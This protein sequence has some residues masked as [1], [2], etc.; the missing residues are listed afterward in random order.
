MVAQVR[1]KGRNWTQYGHVNEENGTDL[2]MA[3]MS[4]ISSSIF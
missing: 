2:T 3:L 1:K 4:L